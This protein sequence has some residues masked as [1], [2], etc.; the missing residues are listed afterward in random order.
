MDKK[1][2]IAI[3]IGIIL[4]LAIIGG[5]SSQSN[6]QKETNAPETQ[7]TAENQ[8]S[9]TPSTNSEKESGEKAIK[10][11]TDAIMDDIKVASCSADDTGVTVEL[12]YNSD[13]KNLIYSKATR[14]EYGGNSHY[15]EYSS[16]KD[17]YLADGVTFEENGELARAGAFEL[18]GGSKTTLKFSVDSF[19]E[20]KD[21]DGFTVY[22]DLKY[23]GA[24]N[25][26]IKDDYIKFRVS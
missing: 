9:N 1:K 20:A 8:N 2:K 21:Y 23:S 5:Q 16:E 14:F 3:A 18:N 24:S 11:K 7:T 26:T 13:E 22:F 15:L 19:V 25:G 12:S 17:A 10:V 6:E 4:V